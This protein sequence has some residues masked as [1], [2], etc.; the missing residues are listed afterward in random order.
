MWCE[1]HSDREG[2]PDKAFVQENQNL[3][4]GRPLTSVSISH[5][6]NPVDLRGPSQRSSAL[7]GEGLAGSR[8][9]LASPVVLGGPAKQLVGGAGTTPGLLQV[10]WRV[11]AR[12]QWQDHHDE[13]WGAEMLPD[14]QRRPERFTGVLG[15]ASPCL[16]CKCWRNWGSCMSG[17]G[18]LPLI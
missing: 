7:W 10:S 8:Q 2:R 16:P 5:W 14:P 1:D 13:S 3:R 11:V 18:Y 4:P 9:L 15:E 12:Q 17:F 6:D